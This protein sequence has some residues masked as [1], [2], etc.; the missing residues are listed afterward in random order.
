MDPTLKKEF[1]VT[2][3]GYMYLGNSM[4]NLREAVLSNTDA[5]LGK[6]PETARQ[7]LGIF[8]TMQS[9]SDI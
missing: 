3:D 7:A 2:A 6:D 1:A 5:L 9:T 4:D 8:D